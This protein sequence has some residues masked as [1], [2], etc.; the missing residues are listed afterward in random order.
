[1]TSFF[2]VLKKTVTATIFADAFHEHMLCSEPLSMNACPFDDV[3]LLY[4]QMLGGFDHAAATILPTQIL[5]PQKPWISAGTIQ[6]LERRKAA[7]LE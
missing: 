7:R 5:K 1:M 4:E 2:S 6:L 3:N